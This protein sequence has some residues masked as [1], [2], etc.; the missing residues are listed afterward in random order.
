MA[1]GARCTCAG[2]RLGVPWIWFRRF[3]VAAPVSRQVALLKMGQIL[4][5]YRSPLASR[6]RGPLADVTRLA[7]FVTGPRIDAAGATNSRRTTP[8][9]SAELSSQYLGLGFDESW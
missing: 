8:P 9:R 6:P 2:A 3:V 4:R 7:C 5:L 1:S